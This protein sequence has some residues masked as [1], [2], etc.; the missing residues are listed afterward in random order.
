MRTNRRVFWG[1]ILL[2]LLGL[3]SLAVIVPELGR[4]FGDYGTLG[5]EADND[6]VVTRV[7]GPPA[8]AAG[9]HEG[10]RIDLVKT[11]LSGRVAV[12]GGMGGM[13][14]VRPDCE[15]RIYVRTRY[16]DGSLGGP[17]LRTLR[18][19]PSPTPA[20]NKVILFLDTLG[21]VFFILVAAA[22]VWQRPNVMTWGFFLYAMWFNPGQFFVWY[23][24]LQRWP[25]ALLAQE[26]AQAVAQ[27][28][29]YAGFI[30]FALR[31][32][33]NSLDRRWRV[34]ERPLPILA[35]ILT[36]L[37]LIGFGAAV[38]YP[39]ESFGWAFYLAGYA[40]DIFVLFIL[41]IR[42]KSQ[43]PEDRQRA[44]R[45]HIRYLRAAPCTGRPADRRRQYRPIS[46]PDQA[47]P[48]AGQL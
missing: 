6:G 30:A 36:V 45:G 47:R 27:G 17:T 37:Q 10:D 44:D 20:S 14:Y 19:V 25:I 29:G 4:V 48:P 13:Q 42:R 11:P 23:A 33:H 5:F 16:A 2:V 9:I 7:T 1:K 46:R 12:F 34:V 26:A 15:V 28:A 8:V 18:A 32:P 31:F 40:I 3:W 21:G 22:L 43:P 39:A 38:G 24:Q 41:H 35:G